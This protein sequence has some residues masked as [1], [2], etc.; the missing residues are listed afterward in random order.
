[1]IVISNGVPKSGTTLLRYYTYQLMHLYSSCSAQEL[2]RKYIKNGTLRGSGEYVE[3]IDERS[4]DIISCISAREGDLLVK[5]HMPPTYTLLRA[6]SQKRILMTF[7]FRDPRD[8]ILSA[9][10]HRLRTLFDADPVFKDFISVSEGTRRTAVWFRSAVAWVDYGL[11][12]IFRYEN[13][14][15][16]PEHEIERLSKYL[17]IPVSI[18]VID[19]I[20]STEQS[21]RLPGK[22]QLNKGEMRRFER[23]MTTE[24]IA[25]CDKVLSRQ[26]TRLGYELHR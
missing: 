18:D 5:T 21:S 17:N 14:V 10:D 12:C 8:V 3:K 20:I 26:I 23:E 11:P 1:M 13:L 19:S 15:Q 16:Q 24:E 7:I 25:F 4:L 2:L 9:M 22:N 6:L